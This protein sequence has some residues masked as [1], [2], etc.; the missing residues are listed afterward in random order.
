M[1][2]KKDKKD[3]KAKKE[4]KSKKSSSKRSHKETRSAKQELVPVD[5]LASVLNYS[6]LSHPGLMKD[7][8]TVLKALD[9]GEFVDV[10]EVSDATSRELLTNLMRYLPVLYNHGNGWYKETLHTKVTQY[11][12]S[13][14]EKVQHIKDGS[15]LTMSESLASKNVMLKLMV[16]LE[17][18]PD[19][20]GELGGLFATLLGGDAIQVDS[21]DNEDIRDGLEDIFRAIG[22]ERT[23]D[24]YSI[25]QGRKTEL[26]TEALQHLGTVF[27]SY[28]ETHNR[29]TRAGSSSTDH[30]HASVI[31]DNPEVPAGNQLTF[32]QD[33]PKEGSRDV[34]GSSSS[35]DSEAGSGDSSSASDDNEGNN[36]LC[37]LLYRELS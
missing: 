7:I 36:S 14:L 6:L 18:F 32:E 12:L 15:E 8:P 29:R 27:E 1:G 35:S 4:K 33:K 22:L 2:S 24:G 11:V 21:L 16:L 17:T 25:P 23:A 37:R 20:K 31:N 9:D 10:N 30:A 5:D 13:Q 34:E 19:L 28:E 3:K 26:V